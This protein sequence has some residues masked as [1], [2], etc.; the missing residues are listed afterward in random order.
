MVIEPQNTDEII[1]KKREKNDKYKC[2]E[3]MD[4]NLEEKNLCQ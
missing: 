3:N 1:I 2:N 4:A